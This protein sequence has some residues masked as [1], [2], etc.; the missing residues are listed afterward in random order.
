MEALAARILAGD[1]RALARGLRIVEDR[2]PGY[3]QLLQALPQTGASAHRIGITGSPGVGKSSLLDALVKEFRRRDRRVAVLAVDPS[4]PLSGGALLGDRVRMGE[5]FLDRS[6]FVRSMANRGLVG[7]L[8]AATGDAIDL[9][10]VAGFDPVFV[11]TV[12]AGQS[13]FEIRNEV[14]TTL[15]VLSPGSGDQIQA[16]KSGIMEIGDFWVVNKSDDPRAERLKVEIAS[17]LS[18]HAAIEGADERVLLASALKGTGIMEIADRLEERV[19]QLETS[20]LRESLLRERLVHRVRSEASALIARRV[21]RDRERVEALVDTII[22][23]EA[24]VES[25]ARE[26]VFDPPGGG[27]SP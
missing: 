3:G 27:E 25:V 20:G 14:E 9:F 19:A 7:G 13:E 8:S 23:G 21:A 11:E 15:V 17:A 16:M 18:L 6:V 22:A 12:G 4:S 10:S 2:V 5:H 24:S 1:R 26:L